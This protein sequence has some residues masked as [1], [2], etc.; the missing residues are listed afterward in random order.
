MPYHKLKTKFIP[1]KLKIVF[2]N[3]RS[4]FHKF[5]EVRKVAPEFDIIVCVESWLTSKHHI[6]IPNFREVRKDRDSR[7]GGIVV[8]VREDVD[9][10]EICFSLRKKRVETC[11]LRLN[12]CIRS[13]DV[14][15]CYWPHYGTMPQEEW[16]EVVQCEIR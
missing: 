8:W 7:A 13:M 15:I 10:S 9:F 1:L 11:W 16:D 2:W 5:S 14:I 6:S 4:I 3:A 12:N